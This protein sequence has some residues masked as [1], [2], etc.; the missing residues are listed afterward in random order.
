MFHQ[1]A[2]QLEWLWGGWISDDRMPQ[3][4]WRGATKIDHFGYKTKIMCLVGGGAGGGAEGR[5]GVKA[6]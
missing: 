6:G 2:T 1:T 3:G 5:M 4:R